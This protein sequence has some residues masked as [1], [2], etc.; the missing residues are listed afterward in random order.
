MIHRRKWSSPL[1]SR[2]TRSGAARL[3]SH[4]I[5]VTGERRAMTLTRRT[6]LRGA[7]ITAA[8]G[9]GLLGT[10]GLHYA[11]GSRPVDWATL[12]G[13]V[14]GGLTVPG[15]PGFDQAKLAFNPLFDGNHPAA[16]ARCA[17][18]DD[19]RASVY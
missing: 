17:T 9:L 14:S 19:V 5:N 7:G 6:F 8:A 13:R 11:A 12:R 1:T 3:S 16:A 18:P 4:K 10:A 2:A 15:E